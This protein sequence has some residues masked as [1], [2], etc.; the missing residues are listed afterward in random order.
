M[1]Q[2]TRARESVEFSI[3]EHLREKISA[4]I[5]LLQSNS[6]RE[7]PLLGKE[8]CLTLGIVN[9]KGEAHTGALR[10][11]VAFL[12]YHGRHNDDNG[13]PIASIGG[14]GDGYWWAR[15][16]EELLE[17]ILNLDKR[18]TS[19]AAVAHALRRTMARMGEAPPVR[20]RRQ[21]RNPLQQEL[22]IQCVAE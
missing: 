1:Q 9:G 13:E 20:R 7:H 2:S 3:G 19:I 22:A 18:W 8:I 12:R 14:K 11:L 17:T 4:F 15:T 5:S 16:P 21:R 6:D 10:G